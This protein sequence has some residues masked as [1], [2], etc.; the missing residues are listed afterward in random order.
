M[1]NWNGLGG[2][3]SW[4]TLLTKAGVNAVVVTLIAGLAQWVT[5]GKATGDW[6]PPAD[7]QTALMS[8]LAGAMAALWAAGKNWS[9]N[10]PASPFAK[11]FGA[12]LLVVLLQGCGTVGTNRPLIYD[13]EFGDRVGGETQ[14]ADVLP[15]GQNTTFK[16]HVKAPAGTKLEDIVGMKYDWNA[17][18]SGKI[19]VSKQ[20]TSDQTAQ[21]DLIKA[22]A[23]TQR[24][25][26][27]D[28][29]T[30]GRGLVTDLAPIAAPLIGQNLSQNAQIKATDQ[31]N[32]LLKLQKQIDAL[33]HIVDRLTKAPKPAATD[34]ITIGTT[35]QSTPLLADP[36]AAL[37]DK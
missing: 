19:A 27:N 30:A 3:F 1:G 21:A 17:D 10:H 12:V 36:G 5:H 4:Q 23:E 26:F 13:M 8:L 15:D 16:V 9:K 22:V 35:A 14:T 7:L 20:A 18:G 29:L 6:T 28:G 32:D 37:P 2:L 33:T 34:S 25:A 24:G 11:L 31:A